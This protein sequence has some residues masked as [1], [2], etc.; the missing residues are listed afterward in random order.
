MTKQQIYNIEN[1]IIKK[2]EVLETKDS[3]NYIDLEQLK[4]DVINLFK[5]QIKEV[6]TNGN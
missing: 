4:S 3:V 2:I 6:K 1:S 5:N